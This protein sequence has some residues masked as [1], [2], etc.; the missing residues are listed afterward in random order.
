MDEQ[1]TLEGLSVRADQTGAFAVLARLLVHG[2][3]AEET[4]RALHAFTEEARQRREFPAAL[5]AELLRVKGHYCR[6]ETGVAH[7]AGLAAATLAREIGDDL[8]EA[9]AHKW[10]AL[11]AFDEGRSKDGH[12]HLLDALAGFETAGAPEE[13]PTLTRW[14]G[15][16]LAFL[17][18]TEEAQRALRLARERYLDAGDLA[19]AR[20]LEADI[21]AVALKQGN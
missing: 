21:A 4:V 7:A 1:I 6:G 5:L 16:H 10:L 2:L 14:Y 15:E 8:A 13:L 19:G 17:G 9:H 3:E 12:D 20:A 11:I 18:A